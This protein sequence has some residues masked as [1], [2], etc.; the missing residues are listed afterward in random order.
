M[1]EE[2]CGLLESK[3][4][5]YEASA[6]SS[7]YSPKSQ[8]VTAKRGVEKNIMIQERNYHGNLEIMHPGSGQ[9]H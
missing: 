1:I 8:Q 7:T 6:F 5:N 2:C 3:R 4:Q 9:Q